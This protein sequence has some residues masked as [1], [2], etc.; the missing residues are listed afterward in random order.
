MRVNC[1]VCFLYI[2]FIRL[3]KLS[4]N[5]QMLN[6]FYYEVVLKEDWGNFGSSRKLPLRGGLPLAPGV[7]PPVLQTAK[8]TK[9]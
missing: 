2:A 6:T 7:S 3:N 4:F 1:A 9:G 8:M 5:P